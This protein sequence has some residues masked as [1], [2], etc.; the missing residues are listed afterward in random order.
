[1]N[2]STT[3]LIAGLL[4]AVATAV[5]G[6]VGLLLAVVFGLIGFLVGAQIEGRLDIVTMLRGG[7]RE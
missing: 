4:V 7:N 1:M 6:F 3:G 5:A 2:L